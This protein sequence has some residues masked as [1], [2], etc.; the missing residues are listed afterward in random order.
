M[1]DGS[2]CVVAIWGTRASTFCLACP[3]G[4]GED[5]SLDRMQWIFTRKGLYT[6]N[7]DSKT[8][9]TFT[10]NAEIQRH[11]DQLEFERFVTA[12]GAVAKVIDG[13][14]TFRAVQLEFERA[15]E[16]KRQ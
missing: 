14:N 4:F 10:S 13:V 9:F 16:R 8:G 11:R 7:D 15:T 2:E 1:A 5:V 3:A 6:V 12:L